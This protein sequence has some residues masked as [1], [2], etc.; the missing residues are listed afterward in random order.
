MD[1]NCRGMRQ[2]IRLSKAQASN[3]GERR[4]KQQL[5]GWVAA[6]AEASFPVAP[7]N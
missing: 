3:G 5:S 6:A 4:Q 2:L 7:R 1:S